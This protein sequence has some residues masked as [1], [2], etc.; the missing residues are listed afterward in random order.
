MLAVNK[1]KKR[2]RQRIV[3]LEIQNY[4]V[5]LSHRCRENKNSMCK[6][7]C[8]NLAFQKQIPYVQREHLPKEKVQFVHKV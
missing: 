7:F 4:I 3:G 8:E 2:Y 5:L 6:R 1:Q